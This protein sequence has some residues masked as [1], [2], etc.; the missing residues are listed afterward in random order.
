MAYSVEDR[1]RARAALRQRVTAQS[2]CATGPSTDLIWKEPAMLRERFTDA[3]KTAMKSGDKARLGAVRLIMSDLKYADVE[4]R[5]AGRTEASDAEILARLQKMVKQRQDS[6][7]MYKQGGRDDLAD[8]EQA[9]IEV[10]TG[11]LPKQM[12]EADVAA[13]IAAAIAETGAASIKDMGKVVAALKAK[14]AGQ[15]DFGKASGLVKAALGG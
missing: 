1:P 9:E 2:G 14:F 6:I 13:A 11:F 7:M 8:A 12:N 4:A 3:M 15:M 5:T 10:I